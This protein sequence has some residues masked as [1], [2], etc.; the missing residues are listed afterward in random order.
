MHL[1]REMSYNKS[2]RSVPCKFEDCLKVGSHDWM[3]RSIPFDSNIASFGR[4]VQQEILF[5]EITMN[6][7]SMISSCSGNKNPM[8]I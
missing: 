2:E 7:C 4:S 3:I 6:E 1:E 5:L 8:K